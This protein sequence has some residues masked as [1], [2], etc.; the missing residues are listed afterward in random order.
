MAGV[1]GAALTSAASVG[2][3]SVGAAEAERSFVASLEATVNWVS[4]DRVTLPAQGWPNLAVR[5]SR[6]REV[7]RKFLS[8]YEQFVVCWYGRNATGQAV[9]GALSGSFSLSLTFWQ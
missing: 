6:L 5:L 3:D 7:S 4:F 1:D 9:L 8:L 2:A